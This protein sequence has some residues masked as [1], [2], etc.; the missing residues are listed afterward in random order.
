[1]PVRIVPNCLA[2]LALFIGVV[3][4]RD[5]TAESQGAEKTWLLQSAAKPGSQ[6]RVVSHLEV[7]GE[8]TVMDEGKNRAL[9]MSVSADQRYEER[10]MEVTDRGR[11]AVRQYEEAKAIIKID[12]SVLKPVLPA[13]RRLI[14]VECGSDGVTLFSLHGP[15]TRDEL[16]L[17]D[18]QANSL[19][20]DQLLPTEA[21]AIGASWKPRSEAWTG[22]L[23]VDAIS[24][25]EVTCSLREVARGKD[26]T[27]EFA[28]ALDG[29][30]DGVATHLELKGRF[31]FDLQAG[32]IVTFSIVVKEQRGIGHVGPGLD[33]VAR[34]QLA[35]API[36]KSSQLTDAALK[37]LPLKLADAESRLRHQASAAEYALLLNR[38]WHVV[39]DRRDMVVLRMIDRGELIAQCNIATPPPSE[40]GTAISLEKF[41]ADIEKA[42][43]ENFGRLVEASTAPGA[44]GGAVHRIIAIGTTNELPIQWNYYLV[45]HPDGRQVVLA[46]TLEQ[47]LRDRLDNSDRAIVD[48][49]EFT[50]QSTETAGQPTPAK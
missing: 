40:P 44:K 35:M 49:L 22:L 16:D 46:F 23:R 41:Q 34:L 30:V 4:L 32:R 36:E 24:S 29:A 19:L 33:L 11:R 42:L 45:A 12:S 18:L 25:T 6:I 27:I 37:G 28:G 8:L 1:M 47:S 31:T 14:G 38:N 9:K 50:T 7:G 15:L 48:G 43:G 13:N 10:L 5:A 2:C 17:V 21:V 3:P 26:A 20:L 39:D